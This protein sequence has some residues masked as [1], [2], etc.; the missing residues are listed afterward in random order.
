MPHYPSTVWSF[1]M[2]LGPGGGHDRRINDGREPL[3]D[4]A[5]NGTIIWKAYPKFGGRDTSQANLE[6]VE[7]ILQEQAQKFGVSHVWITAGA[8]QTSKVGRPVNGKRPTSYDDLHVTVRMGTAEDVC[9]LHGHIYIK[10]QDNDP[11]KKAIRMMEEKE[12]SIEDGKSPQLWVWGSYPAH[13]P[14]SNVTYPKIPWEIKE[15][16]ILDKQIEKTERPRK[17]AAE[18][19]ADLASKLFQVQE[20]ARKARDEERKAAE[21][22]EKL[23]R[24]KLVKRQMKNAFFKSKKK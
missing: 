13:Y 17:E 5:G 15:G 12:R 16:S 10:F 19:A 3:R 23:A 21:L 14:R 11:A 8:H 4:T 7:K 20:K 24:E 2:P 18:K 6:A 22:A 1:G 9:N